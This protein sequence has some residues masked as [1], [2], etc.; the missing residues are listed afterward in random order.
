MTLESIISTMRVAGLT[1]QADALET[2]LAAHEKEKSAAIACLRQMDKVTHE[3]AAE[4][5]TGSRRSREDDAMSAP[6]LS[7]KP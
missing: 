1:P 3:N 4:E 7:V 6:K 2:I 5:T